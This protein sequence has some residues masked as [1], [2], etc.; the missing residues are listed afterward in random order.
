MPPCRVAPEVLLGGQTCTSAVDIY[1]S[2]GCLGR[3]QLMIACTAR[4]RQAPAAR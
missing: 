4:L 3:R 2:A 1:R